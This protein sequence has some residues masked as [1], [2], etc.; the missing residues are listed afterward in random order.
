MRA[1]G[2]WSVV[3]GHY[4]HRKRRFSFRKM[5]IQTCDYLLVYQLDCANL[6]RYV[7][8]MPAFVGCLQMHHTK[9]RSAFKLA[10]CRLR[11][12]VEVCVYRSRCA[13]Y[14]YDLH[15]SAHCYAS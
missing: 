9:I 5:R 2:E 6:I 7:A 11:L 14:L 4:Q 13:R 15:S 1:R 12:A 10:D 8:L 3:V